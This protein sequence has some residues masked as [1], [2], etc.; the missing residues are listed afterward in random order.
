LFPYC[1]HAAQVISALSLCFQHD[2]VGFLEPERF[3]RL[4][5]AIASQLDSAPEGAAATA[6]DSAASAAGRVPGP[7][8]AAA[9]PIGVFGW[10]LVECLSNMAVASGTDDHWRPLH[11]AVLMTTRS[12]SVRTK[13]TALEVRCG[14]VCN[15][16]PT[17]A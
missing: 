13:L 8:G 5:P 15:L 11:H 14:R 17:R 2:S 12:D 9:S 6:V 16:E 7:E 3:E 4:L 10:A 1:L